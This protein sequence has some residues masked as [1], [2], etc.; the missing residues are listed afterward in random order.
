MTFSLKAKNLGILFIMAVLYAVSV[1]LVY[2]YIILPGFLSLEVDEARKNIRRPIQAIERE[3]DHLKSFVHDWAA[4]TE[5]YEFIETKSQDYV[6]ANIPYSSFHDNR[7]NLILF[8][9]I[10]GEI[11]W[12]GMYD[13]KTKQPLKI[14]EIP[15]KS[16]SSKD[17]LI[18]WPNSEKNLAELAV[19]GI[20][21]TAYGPML[22]V[23]R[24]V[25]TNDNEGPIRGSVIMGRFLTTEIVKKLARQTEVNFTVLPAEKFNDESGV[26]T[27]T[28]MTAENK[29]YLYVADRNL[30]KGFS[31]MID[32]DKEP[33]IIINAM[34][35]RDIAEKGY[36]IMKYSVVSVI[37]AGLIIFIAMFIIL[38]IT[39]VRPIS[40][41][42]KHTHEVGRTGN[43]SA[44][45][46]FSRK[47][48]IGSLARRLDSMLEQLEQAR[49]TLI[50][51][52]Y[53][54]GLGG[55]ASDILHNTR[56]I[57]TPVSGKLN[58]IMSECNAI[59]ADTIEKAI[60]ELEQGGSS[61]ERSESLIRYLN[62]S[63]RHFLN[64]SGAAK[65][66]LTE[67]AGHIAE[68]EHMLNDIDA[69]SRLQLSS[70]FVNP[71]DLI[72]NA[73]ASISGKYTQNLSINISEK[74]FRLPS[75]HVE[76][77]TTGTVLT[78]LLNYVTRRINIS[79]SNDTAGID[80]DAF[81]ETKGGAPFIHIIITG[82]GFMV[83][84]EELDCLFRR[85]EDG[86]H[87][88]GQLIGLHWCSNVISAAGGRL[89]ALTGEGGQG[90][91]F[92]LTLPAGETD[93]S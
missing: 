81:E 17:R 68:I 16:F 60:K 18:S 64:M 72:E 73:V 37:V 56:N 75:F 11:V 89:A 74:V 3:I 6:E 47:D 10:N 32:I 58:A 79:G 9:D 27:N 42:A 66:Q 8:C 77:V 7:I 15:E 90:I 30:L 49:A 35:K 78:T 22:T 76:R 39:T 52:S 46:D 21:M 50:E 44:R 54:A 19:S 12:K 93:D 14:A 51:Q 67:I 48:E 38:D 34:M 53:Y 82:N 63:V 43:M 55:L 4:W 84:R 5:T 61:E 92:H 80:I 36:T 62:L 71:Y 2:R 88:D 83:T 87:S 1:F 25:L 29:I 70:E 45:L 91:V 33:A 23:S 85:E 69:Y 86:R 40:L 20:M 59:P 13:L 57:L 31:L 41:M 26:T 65:E 28:I 24:P